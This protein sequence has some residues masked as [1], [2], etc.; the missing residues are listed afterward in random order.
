[1]S[2][3]AARIVGS[4]RSASETSTTADGHVAVAP[5]MF[6]LQAVGDLSET[7]IIESGRNRAQVTTK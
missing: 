1:M 2:S 3:A 7:V 5:S 4:V 6:G